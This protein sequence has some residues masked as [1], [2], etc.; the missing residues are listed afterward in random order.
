[1]LAQQFGANV[2]GILAA[3]CLF[4]LLFALNLAVHSYLITAYAA[5]D[6]ISLNIGFYYSANSLGRL[7]GT[8]LSGWCY[9]HW[10]IVGSMLVAGADVYPCRYLCVATPCPQWPDR[11]Q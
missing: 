6:A 5:R 7:V 3:V 10:G 2:W 11:H 4:S 1:M 8:L 9:L